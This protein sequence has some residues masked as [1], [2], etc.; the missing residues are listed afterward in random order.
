[1]KKVKVTPK[2]TGKF[3]VG[4]VCR[5]CGTQDLVMVTLY[6]ETP[7]MTGDDHIW[8]VKPICCTSEV[9]TWYYEFELRKINRYATIK[10]SRGKKKGFYFNLVADNGEI[11]GTSEIY[12]THKKAVQTLKKYFP[13]FR[14]ESK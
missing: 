11:V 4:D 3:Q 12:T 9:E 5:I 2:K 8:D 1:M 10:S 13:T 7:S 6:T 14:I